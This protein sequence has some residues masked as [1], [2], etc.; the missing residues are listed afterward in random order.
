MPTITRAQE[1]APFLSDVIAAPDPIAAL[2]L[3]GQRLSPGLRGRVTSNAARFQV[4]AARLRRWKELAQ[5]RQPARVVVRGS[6]APSAP[7]APAAVGTRVLALAAGDYD[8]IAGVGLD[9]VDQALA[10]LWQTWAIPQ[11]I[12]LPAQLEGEDPFDPETVLEL[13]R[14]HFDGI[15][16]GT[17]VRVGRLHFTAPPTSEPV[18]GRP[19]LRLAMPFTLDVERPVGVRLPRRFEVVTTLEGT[20]HATVEIATPLLGTP[21]Q[22]D[23]Q[24]AITVQLPSEIEPGEELVIEVDPSSEVQPSEPLEG[25]AEVLRRIVT[26]ALES[27]GGPQIGPGELAGWTVSPLI[28]LPFGQG[29]QPD[30][31][32]IIQDVDARAV[33]SGDRGAIMVGI[34]STSPGAGDPGARL[35][36]PF[37]AAEANGGNF[38]L[39]VHEDLV[40]HVA[41]RALDAGELE[42]LARAQVHDA[43]R[44]DRIAEVS[45]RPGEVR[46]RIA[47]RVEDACPLGADLHFESTQIIK[48]DIVDGELVVELDDELDLLDWDNIWCVLGTVLTLGL[49]FVMPAIMGVAT[50]GWLWGLLVG[51][52]GGSLLTWLA[53]AD[54]P[55]GELA[56]EAFTSLFEDGGEDEPTVIS[57][58]RPIPRTELLT[59]PSIT[60]YALDDVSLGTYGRLAL[61]PDNV[62]TFVYVRFLE[63]TGP[64]GLLRRPVEGMDVALR[65]QDV[66][67][68]QGD[69]AI[70]PEEKSEVVFAN[71]KRIVTR[72]V[73]FEAPSRD[74]H[75]ATARTDS[76]GVAAFLL[77][78]NEVRTDAGVVVTTTVTEI[79]DV[80]EGPELLDGGSPPRGEPA[81]IQVREQRR[82][83]LEKPDVYFTARLPSGSFVDTRSLA[84]GLVMNLGSRRIGTASEPLTFV[85]GRAAG[86]EVLDPSISRPPREPSRPELPSRPEPT[87]R[88]LVHRDDVDRPI[89]RRPGRGRV[90]G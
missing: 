65:D 10:G 74:D 70:V 28:R 68:P 81:G 18:P 80:R 20:L 4:P 42:R 32:I 25:F 27:D 30:P 48:F 46:V 15:P 59:E 37:A 60:G 57:L 64:L 75:L 62:D 9:V 66:P 73:R 29:D 43:V 82:R 50:L 47:G 51:L 49:T 21:G 3:R 41:Q 36:D 17:D 79:L 52:A 67:R 61:V 69:D 86:S 83:L 63:R 38:Y 1:L 89:R 19:R 34:R 6:S 35:T 85:V 84:S 87:E 90:P 76:R 77:T 5:Q 14:T 39:R 23:F 53:F 88:V 33:Q 78:P 54:L 44:I 11:Q 22:S 12:D 72:T 45:F 8:V 71:Q 26:D 2:E 58:R 13:L 7:P 16:D 31:S 40:R 56:W 55:A 24:L